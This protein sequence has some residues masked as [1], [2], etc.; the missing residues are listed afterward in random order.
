MSERDSLL[1]RVAYPGTVALAAILVLYVVPRLGRM[2]SP[3]LGRPAPEFALAVVYNGDPGNRLRLSDLKGHPIALDFFAHWCAPCRVE[4]PLLD[5]IARRH[6]ER[7]LVVIGVNT[8]DGPGDGARF[9][10]ERNLSYPI[11]Y[12]ENG[13]VAARYAVD[14]L[15]TLVV[16]DA[17]G[18]VIA[19]RTGVENEAELDR[20]VAPAL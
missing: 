13:T 19:V 12:D 2:K 20:V 9:A 6:R 4:A 5:R 3:L 17:K 11:V 10:R 7:G 1:R 14:G 8:S 16:I 15:P 18:D